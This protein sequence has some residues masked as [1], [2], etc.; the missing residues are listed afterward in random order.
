MKLKVLVFPAGTEIAMEIHRA[1]RHSKF[2]ELYGATSIPCHAD[3]VF[4]NCVEVPFVS[5]PG[6][7][8]AM[9]DVIDKF[10]I[11][12]VYPAHDDALLRLTQEAH[13]LHARVVTTSLKTVDICR[14]KK[15]T[16]SYLDGRNY[17][18]RTYLSADSVDGFPVFIKPDIGQGGTGTMLIESREKLEEALTSE[19]EYVICEYLPGEEVT[20]DC[21]TDTH[22]TL[23]YIGPRTRD[24]IRSGIAARSKFIPVTSEI[25]DI[26]EDL[27]RTFDFNGAWFFQLKKNREGEYRLMEVAPRIAGTMGLSRNIGVNLPLLTL[28]NMERQEVEIL[29]NGNRL[30]LDRA[31][32]ARYD[33]GIEWDTVYV[34]F[35]DTL[36]KGG[37]V[38]PFLMAFLYQQRN[39]GKR[40]VCLSRRIGDVNWEMDWNSIPR[41]L[42]HSI[43]NVRMNESKAA[44]VTEGGIFIDDSFAERKAVHQKGIPVF[45]VDM[46]ESLFDWRA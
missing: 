10:G 42:F 26:A 4:K 45:D 28:Y 12:Y 9:N 15:R 38:N 36:V 7:I 25:R 37:N 29:S 40:L 2:V 33:P 35:D 31:F 23:R 43:V 17:V 34:D 20:V 24:R 27:N 32:I 1:L 44:Y 41:S 3:F 18:P 30:L 21:F 5:K 22:K 16:Y 8:D 46:V 39:K 6:F 14:S 19:T 11:D 13:S